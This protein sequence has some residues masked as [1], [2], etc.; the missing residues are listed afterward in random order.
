MES[1]TEPRRPRI[2]FRSDLSGIVCVRKD[3]DMTSF[4]V[5]KAV[6]KIFKVKKVGHTGTLD[7]FATGVLPVCLNK[8]TR[9]ASIVTDLDKTYR[10]VIRL[11]AESDTYDRTGSVKVHEGVMLPDRLEVDAALG[12]FR[13]KILQEPPLFSAVKVEGKPLYER[14]RAG[15]TFDMSQKVREVTLYDVRVNSYVPPMLDLTIRCSKGT[16]LRS[17]AHDLGRKLG[18]GGLLESLVRE[19]VGPLTL[20]R[21]FSL[22]EL[23]VE[24][25]PLDVGSA[26]SMYEK[27]FFPADEILEAIPE[28][29]VNRA[30]FLELS[31]GRITDPDVLIALAKEKNLARAV[32]T[33]EAG[34]A[35]RASDSAG[36][37]TVLIECQYPEGRKTGQKFLK[38]FRVLSRGERLF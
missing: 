1:V 27:W 3:M 34:G 11:G 32:E 2:E 16:Y 17:I 13:G 38:P 8:A 33:L 26:S 35:I 29:Q 37:G 28:I 9:F 10:G 7:P 36:R 12:S 14:A 23:D 19:A 20:E 6:K 5:V 18:T 25:G 4:A 31:D 21:S 22:S 30:D 15:E 24:V